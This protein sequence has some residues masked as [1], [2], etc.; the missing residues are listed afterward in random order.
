MNNKSLAFAKRNLLEMSRDVLSYI[1]CII[2][3]IVMLVIMT[4]VNESIPKESGMTIFRIDNLTGGVI[5]FGQFFIMLFSAITLANDRNSFFLVRLFSTPMKSLDFILGYFLPMLF[6]ALI[7][8]TLTLIS[9]LIISF[10][11]GYTLSVPGLLLALPASVPSAVMFTATGLIFGSIF[12]EKAAPGIC[13]VIISLGSFLGGIWFD[14]EGTG[15]ILL[16]ISKCTPL[17]YC[18]KVTRSSIGLDLSA[19]AFRLPFMLV[20]LCAVI[21]TTL[22]VLVFTKKMKADLA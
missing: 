10:I 21:L 6:I 18:T 8:T 5:I 9:A 3:P 7:Q 1:F 2:F 20:S 11:T 16:K 15:G 12:S 19:S 22:A 17:L 14:A 4:V 13:S